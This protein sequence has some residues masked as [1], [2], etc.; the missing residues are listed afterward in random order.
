MDAALAEAN[1]V[2]AESLRLWLEQSMAR[3]KMP[4]EIRYDWYVPAEWQP[5]PDQA[6]VLDRAASGDERLPLI[7][8]PAGPSSAGVRF[9]TSGGV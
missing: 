3:S 1:A 6:G 4:L 9:R 2:S 5:P 7:K 8:S